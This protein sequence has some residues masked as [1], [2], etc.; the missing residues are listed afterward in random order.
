MA[1][2]RAGNVIWFICLY[3]LTAWRRYSLSALNREHRNERY[4]IDSDVSEC[5]VSA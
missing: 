1:P 5:V 3:T 4:L 2:G